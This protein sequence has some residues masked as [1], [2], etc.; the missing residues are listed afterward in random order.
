MYFSMNS[1]RVLLK[2]TSKV[3]SRKVYFW[4]VL[5]KWTRCAVEEYPQCLL[6]KCT[7]EV[8]SCIMKSRKV[9]M[10][11]TPDEYYGVC[12]Y[13]FLYKSSPLS[14]ITVICLYRISWFSIVKQGGF[15]VKKVLD[16]RNEM[17]R[18]NLA[19]WAYQAKNG[20]KQPILSWGCLLIHIKV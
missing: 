9:L 3:F 2:C 12:L 6:F 11:S 8:Y 13:W 17:N 10:K 5:S 4:G 14:P 7:L 20:R 18:W 1:Q 19:I 16:T 15:K